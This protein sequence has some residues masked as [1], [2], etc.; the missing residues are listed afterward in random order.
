[1]QVVWEGE[2]LSI[3]SQ[4]NLEGNLREA[5]YFKGVRW[6]MEKD[7]AVLDATLHI[8][9]TAAPVLQGELKVERLSLPQWFGFAR[10]LPLGL[11]N[12]LDALQG[13]LH[14]VLDTQ[15]LDVHKLSATAAEA[16][17]TGRGGVKQW[18]KPVISLDIAG[19]FL[20]LKKVYPEIEAED[21]PP[22]SFAH[23]PL[24]ALS[25]ATTKE[26]DASSVK[27]HY[28]IRIGTKKLLAWDLLAEDM[29]FR[30]SSAGVDGEKV[31]EKHKDAVFL[32]FASE[33]LYGGRAE[34]DLTLYRLPSQD[35]AYDIRG[36][37]RNVE[38]VKPVQRLF[39][40]KFLEGR[41]NVDTTFT[42]KGG[43][44]SE[45][46][47]SQQGMAALR[48]DNGQAY[49]RDGKAF[50][51]ILLT[52]AS[53]FT[54][55]NPS[56]VQGATLPPSLQYSGQWNGSLR[57]KE[58]S[59]RASWN[60][61]ASLTGQDYAT[62]VLREVPAR[63]NV[64]LSPI[65]TDFSSPINMDVDGR[66]SLNT[67]TFTASVKGAQVSIPDFGSLHLSGN[68]SMNF[69]KDF[70]CSA[71]IKGGAASLSELLWRMS[72]QSKSL[73]PSGFPQRLKGSTKLTYAQNTLRLDALSLQAHPMHLKGSIQRTFS[74]KSAWNFTLSLNSFDF[75]AFF[76]RKSTHSGLENTSHKHQASAA[77]SWG[78]LRGFQA[79]GT[80]HLGNLH[81]K[82]MNIS[83]ISAPIH[84]ENSRITC[85]PITASM[86]DGTLRLQFNGHVQGTALQ[87]RIVMNT[88]DVSLFALTQDLGMQTALS[89]PASLSLTLEGPLLQ[90]VL[91][92]LHGK[93]NVHV[94]R[95]FMQSRNS[96][97]NLTG[98]PTY[99]SSFSD[100]G[101][102]KQGVLHSQRFFLMGPDLQ[103]TGK[104]QVNLL[105]NTLDM[106][107][108]ANLDTVVD[109][110]VRYFGSL[111]NPQRDLN[112]GAVVL[113]T[114]GSL[115][116]GIFDLLGGIFNILFGTF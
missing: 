79:K 49:S 22:L 10:A 37:V 92:G 32:H 28:D 63:V 12:T 42:A 88:Q 47:L 14:F 86:Y 29:S 31:P 18:S 104:G 62:L 77:R 85:N 26:E 53:D 73:V 25:D 57:T 44:V 8:K 72:N 11:R 40:Y 60:G 21:A 33:K 54:A 87:S 71:D 80:F 84:I 13:H 4:G 64:S 105:Q 94:G 7:A 5:L 83:N 39:G 97:G 90:D 51:F 38:A 15:G 98:K 95:G 81:I 3:Q 24:L 112:D 50:P 6:Q 91:A 101:T 36:I 106:H 114:I 74:A 67:Q 34:G 75:D 56:K 68:A 93:W 65:L 76:G 115:G 109:I 108:L 107:L 99:I 9:D 16:H 1:M 59:T 48:I 45:F 30:C 35:M 61:T 2:P 46:L 20:Q 89:G 52:L 110:P 55:Q 103:V 41:M 27:V 43:S 111:S 70:S 66:F 102:L 23:T 116:T 96:R 19:D 17:F 100:H 58:F 78:W 82:E 113:A 69:A